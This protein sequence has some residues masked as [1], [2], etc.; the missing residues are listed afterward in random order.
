MFVDTTLPA[1]AEFEMVRPSV[2][3][4]IAAFLDG[5]THGEELLHALYDHVLDEPIPPQMKALLRG[6]RT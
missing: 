1:A 3:D 2:E 4:Q 5:R 6:E